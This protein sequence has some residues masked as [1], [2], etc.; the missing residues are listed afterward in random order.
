MKTK[1]YDH[2]ID[3][4]N[5][6]KIFPKSLFILAGAGEENEDIWKKYFR[7]GKMQECSPVITFEQF[8]ERKLK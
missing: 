7:D 6:S 3:L 1:W 4:K 2:E 5:F 8:D